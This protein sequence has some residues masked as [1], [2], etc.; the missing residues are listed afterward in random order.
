[1][2]IKRP[3][4]SRWLTLLLPIIIVVLFPLAGCQFGS[5]DGKLRIGVLPILDV[6]PLYVAEQEGYFNQ[7]GIQ[8][9]LLPFA[10]ALERDT[11]FQA[12]QIDGEVNDLI[13]TVLLTK[14][15]EKARIV[16]TA[17]RA[18]PDKAMFAIL[19]AGSSSIAKPADLKGVEI[20]VSTNTVIEYVVDRLL[21]AEGLADS[22]IARTE[23]SKI[24]VR[25]ELLSSG[26]VSAA[27]LPEPLASLA[28]VQGARIVIDDRSHPEFGQSVVTVA[29]RTLGRKPA[30][31]KR[32]L[33]AYEKAVAAINAEPQKFRSLLIDKGR[34][35]KPVQDSFQMPVFPKA[36]VPTDKE[37]SDVVQWMKGKGLL[38]KDLTY[39][40]LV[41]ASYLPKP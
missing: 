14:D 23:V 39:D 24:P 7:E 6:L 35:P 18:T 32:F 27:C 41:T 33:A 4:V 28:I 22:D 37:V 16:R 20:A 29:S 2:R 31:V 40:R 13:S 38:D 36:E 19:A 9:E 5:E 8:V 3:E 25:L 1:M 30:T 10:S 17:M 15:Q 12:D 34:V 26:Q 11:A 21:Q